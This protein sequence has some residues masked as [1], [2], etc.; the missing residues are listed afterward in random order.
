MSKLLRCFTWLLLLSLYGCSTL[1]LEPIKPEQLKLL[2][3]IEGPPA[4]LLKQTVT[5]EKLG[6]QRQFLVVARFNSERLKLVALL[7]AGQQILSLEYDGQKLVQDNLPSMDIPGEEILAIMQFAL[8]PESSVRNS[9]SESD[10][11]TVLL[12][13]KQRILKTETGS[14]LKVNYQEKELIVNNYL[15]D[16]RVTIHTLE[17]TQL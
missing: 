5:M 12:D 13:T 8:W 14:V 7:P 15:H 3:P 10:G 4:A 9:Y 2:P 6:Q 16:Y 17:A 1:T 11:W